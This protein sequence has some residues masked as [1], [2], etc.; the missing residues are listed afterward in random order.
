MTG[1]SEA[2]RSHIEATIAEIE[3]QTAAELVVVSI[4]RSASYSEIKLGYALA[5]SLA[6]GAI[7]H[8]V[9]PTH[10]VQ[11]LLWLQLAA[12]LFTLGFTSLPI[13]LRRVVPKAVLKHWVNQRAHLA[14]LE[15]GLFATRDRTGVLIML[16]EL[17]RR[18]VILGDSGIHAKVQES[19]WQAHVDH[20][21]AAIHAGRIEQGVCETL[22]ALGET[23][24]KEFP[25]RA[26]D[27]DE[28]PNTVRQTPR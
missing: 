15:H 20:I 8:T 7:G 19:G 11:W 16:S 4:G 25:R 2:G 12:A 17:E 27:V 9:W 24:T 14:F 21:V 6:A 1:L 18:V 22:R 26:D 5:L 13:V 10:S 3:L 23:L 28:L